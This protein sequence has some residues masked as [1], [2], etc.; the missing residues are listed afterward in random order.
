[1]FAPLAWL[2]GHNIIAQ[3][4]AT[5]RTAFLCA[6][7]KQRIIDFVEPRDA[8]AL[9]RV[10]HDWRQAVTSRVPLHGQL[11]KAGRPVR[12][13]EKIQ[14]CVREG[15]AVALRAALITQRRRQVQRERGTCAVYAIDVGTLQGNILPVRFSPDAKLAIVSKGRAP[16]ELWSLNK[17]RIRSQP[18]GPKTGTTIAAAFSPSGKQMAVA[19]SVNLLSLYHLKGETPV[20][21]K[22]LETNR[23]WGQML[24]SPDGRFL[25]LADSR[26]AI[27]RVDVKEVDAAP[28]PF[29]AGAGMVRAWAFSDD[30]THLAAS[31]SDQTIQIFDIKGHA[32][33]LIA[34]ID[35]HPS[36]T[37]LKFSQDNAYLT[38][39]AS[40]GMTRLFKIA[41]PARPQLFLDNNHSSL[42]RLATFIDDDR[43]LL[44]VGSNGSVQ[45][46][47]WHTSPRKAVRIVEDD[48]AGFVSANV[49]P[50]KQFLVTVSHY[51]DCDIVRFW[52]LVDPKPEAREWRFKGETLLGATFSEDGRFVVAQGANG[53]VHMC[54]FDL[55]L[56]G[57]CAPS[58]ETST[59]TS[60]PAPWW[61]RLLGWK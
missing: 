3:P 56:A 21:H 28:E 44:T 37:T 15:T 61:Y 30:G 12:P 43:V 24:F 18:L 33:Q 60:G 23:A 10:N 36:A 58:S 55:V 35:Q 41:T 2:T 45:V 26:G 19:S 34:S 46:C 38:T 22:M 4:V 25:L 1:M 40:G 14:G 39:G 48:A 8:V 32:P 9:L 31:L 47:D 7:V 49:S 17:G 5:D 16:T 20:L 59:R 27:A 51:R 53:K 57:I 29:F 54:D 11:T 52:N 42:V 6:E 50:D 13:Y